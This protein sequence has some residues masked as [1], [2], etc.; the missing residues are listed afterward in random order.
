M[1]KN[2]G[3]VAVTFIAGIWLPACGR[4]Q[5]SQSS[6][7]AIAIEMVVEPAQPRV[8]PANLVFTVTDK[9]GRPVND[10]IL[11]VEGNMIHAGMS[12]VSTHAT[13]NKDGRYTV[14]LEWTMAGD[15]IVT[16]N[17]SLADGQKFVREFPVSVRNAADKE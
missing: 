4:I 2:I 6:D 16:V 5:Q 17:V 3:L 12:P 9:A 14:P 15:W 11:E 8:G 13:T 10:A 1:L 7:D